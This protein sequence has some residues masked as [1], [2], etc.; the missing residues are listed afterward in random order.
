M[1]IYFSAT[2]TSNEKL[3]E[4]YYKTIE[5]LKKDSHSVVEYRSEALDPAILAKMTDSEMQIEYKKLDKSLRNAEVY[6]ADISEPSITVGYEISQALMHRKPVLVLK[7]QKALFHPMTSIQGNKSVYLKFKTYDERSFYS[8]VKRFLET[9]K[10]KIDTKFILI[11]P[12][13]IDRYLEWN[14]RER[15][16]PKAEVT[17]EAIERAMKDDKNYQLH[18]KNDK[19]TEE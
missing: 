9:A 6:M 11:I 1:K 12:P 10:D 8:I 5:Q 15:G 3:K 4:L 7:H 16:V 13:T 19:I 17:R 18:L 2:I 14:T